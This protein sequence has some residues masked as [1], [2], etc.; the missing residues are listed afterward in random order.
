M[1]TNVKIIV[2]AL[3]AVG[4]V[5]PLQQA[6]ADTFG[7]PTLVPPTAQTPATPATYTVTYP[8]TEYSS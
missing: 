3:C 2:A 5:A 4:V 7:P 1:K 8:V 6:L